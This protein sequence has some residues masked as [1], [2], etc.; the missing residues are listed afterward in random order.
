MT[1]FL[2]V[3]IVFGVMGLGVQG[4]RM[5]AK[6]DELKAV[7]EENLAAFTAYALKVDT[8]HATLPQVIADAVAAKAAGD[9]AAVAAITDQVKAETARIADESAKVTAL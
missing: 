7:I 4:A 5:S 9:D 8:F 6:V 3:V 2:L 1:T